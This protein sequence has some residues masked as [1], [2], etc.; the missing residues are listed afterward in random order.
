MRH[1]D[2]ALLRS[3][4]AVVE[5]GSATR[6]GA[7]VHLTQAAVSQQIRRLEEGLEQTL[8]DREGHRLRLTPTGERLLTHARRLLSLNDE[9]WHLMR[10]PDE[11][12][13]VRLGVPSDLSHAFLAPILKSFCEQW[14]RVRV[15][16]LG[17]TTAELRTAY[18]SG[19]V[20]LFLA[21]ER[22]CEA[23]GEVL[24]P[25]LLVWVGARNGRAC[26]QEPLPIAW[27]HARCAF[28]APVL[29]TLGASGRPWRLM[30]DTS[31]MASLTAC[32][33]VDIAVT[34]MLASAIPANLSP[35]PDEAG[36]PALPPFNVNLYPAPGGSARP[37]I[38]LAQ[39]IRRTLGIR[40]RLQAEARAA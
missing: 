9:V 11:D 37:A 39:C 18:A 8:F 7:R 2:L 17:S 35:V 3:F 22:G 34:A 31:D 33:E 10:A 38:D 23:A 25:D 15:S 29:E 27:G 28:R 5:S 40:A 12:G 32:I 4:V 24:Y 13:E 14:P 19:Q 36:L 16:V 6:A 20:D 26:L 1:L 21:T 30:G